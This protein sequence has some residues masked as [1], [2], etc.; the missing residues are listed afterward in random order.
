MM[1]EVINVDSSDAEDDSDDVSLF[2]DEV[3]A[4]LLREEAQD[5]I[6]AEAEADAII[7]PIESFLCPISWALFKDP[8]VCQDGVTYERD[9]INQWLEHSKMSPITRVE[10]S[11]TT[12]YRN[13]ALKNAME[14][15]KEFTRDKKDTHN[16]LLLAMTRTKKML[17][18]AMKKLNKLESENVVLKDTQNKLEI[19]KA[20][21]AEELRREKAAWMM[22]FNKI[23]RENEVMKSKLEKA[24]KELMESQAKRKSIVEK[25]SDIV[26]NEMATMNPKSNKKAKR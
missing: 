19:E 6:E 9:N 26:K 13:I 8:V 22:G 4:S 3:V 1:D 25:M 24:K 2:T 10:I 16:K 5:P 14:E 18:A 11:N 7:Y 20:A 23:F 17:N 15:F 21:L 12:Q